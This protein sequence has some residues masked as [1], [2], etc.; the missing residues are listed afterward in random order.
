MT[1]F[2]VAAPLI[3]AVVV[4]LFSRPLGRAAGA[5]CAAI[6]AAVFALLLYDLL[7]LPT[8]DSAHLVSIPWAPLAGLDLNLRLDGLS[9]AFGLLITGIGALVCLYAGAYFEGDPRRGRFLAFLLFFMGAMLGVVFADNVLVLFVFWELTSIASYL[10]IGFEHG[11]ASA[12]N[13]ALQALLTT[14]AGGLAMLAGLILLGNAAG[15]FDLSMIIQT[16]GLADHPHYAA[17]V[18]LVLAGAATKSAQFPFHFWLPNAMAAP[19]PASA[20]LHSSTMVKAGVYLLARLSPALGGTD[21]WFWLLVGIGSATML[22]AGWLALRQT[23]LKPMLA[24]ST[25]VALGTLV[26][27]LGVGTPLAIKAFKV[28]LFV[29]ALYKAALFMVAGA[30]LHQAHESCV[31][32]L[33]GLGR[34]MPVT[35]LA[36]FVAALSMAGLPPL[37]GFVGK[38]SVYEA[39]LHAPVAAQALVAIAILANVTNVYVAFAVGLLPFWRQRG[40]HAPVRGEVSPGLWLG[41]ITLGALGLATGLYPGVL[42]REILSPGGHIVLGEDLTFKLALW[43]GVNTAFLL[44]LVT[45]GLGL[46]IF[47]LRRPWR[48]AAEWLA[49]LDRIGPESIY[50]GMLQGMLWTSRTCT[51]VLQ[52]GYL[53]YYLLLVL[54][55]LILSV[56]GALQLEVRQDAFEPVDLRVHELLTVLLIAVAAFSTTRIRSRFGALACLGVVGYGIALLYVYYG[57]PDLAKTQI[58]VESLTVVFFALLAAAM[59]GFTELTAKAVRRRD[60]VIAAI[61]GSLMGVL[62]YST[63][64]SNQAQPVAQYYREH[65]LPLA[66]GRNVVN[67]ILVDFRA[68]D[69]LGE[70]TVL[71]VAAFGAVAM[72]RLWRR[73]RT[74]L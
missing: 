17:I 23:A 55:C 21:L 30:I 60:A 54:V 56:A 40:D 41:P 6:P 34:A 32:R 44:S 73:G 11:K 62:V 46:G 52:H 2:I 43:H 50:Q 42:G 53:R 16:Q 20:Y 36:A 13:A 33:G 28:F 38:E 51:S 4:P 9:I 74:T 63:L 64:A 26:L 1:W 25:V 3:G 15:S 61:A 12:R 18:L 31:E 59:T 45:L 29:H 67:V 8:P 10:L 72:L 69:T 19:T 5:V 22:A 39:L 65:S 57:A 7:H 49:A 47:F 71:A 66:H 27:C 35:A 68:L 24:Y 58:V 14:G 48:R 37:L 70:I